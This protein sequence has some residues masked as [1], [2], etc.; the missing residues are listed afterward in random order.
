MCGGQVKIYGGSEVG[1]S[2]VLVNG[3]NMN[4]NLRVASKMQRSCCMLKAL[5]CGKKWH[6]VGF[7]PMEVAPIATHNL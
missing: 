1:E 3:D 2:R 6:Q 5:K 7:Y 4:M